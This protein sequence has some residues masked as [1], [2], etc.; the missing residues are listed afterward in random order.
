MSQSNLSAFVRAVETQLQARDVEFRL[1][2]LIAQCSVFWPLAR[3]HADP[4]RWARAS[5]EGRGA[6][7]Q[8]TFRPALGRGTLPLSFGCALTPS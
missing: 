2:D 4:S 5:L 1:C 8:L 7:R 3:E 6:G